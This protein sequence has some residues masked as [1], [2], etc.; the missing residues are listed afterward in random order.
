MGGAL[1]APALSSTVGFLREVA[2]PCNPD[3]WP[4]Y[5]GR[6][7]PGSGPISPSLSCLHCARRRRGVNVLDDQAS[8]LPTRRRPGPRS[9][10]DLVQNGNTYRES[11]HVSC[12]ALYVVAMG[13]DDGSVD[14]L[15][16]GTARTEGTLSPTCGPCYEIA[17]ELTWM[18][19]QQ[20]PA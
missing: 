17:G 14:I 6:D 8:R 10:P 12:G 5:Y 15:R 4:S 2:V 19:S 9:Q 7:N 16:I 11:A 1:V 20:S 18:I 13:D 3:W